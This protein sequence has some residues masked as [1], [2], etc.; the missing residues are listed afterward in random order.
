MPPFLVRLSP[1][2]AHGKPWIRYSLALL[3]SLLAW[4]AASPARAAGESSYPF[5]YAFAAVILSAGWAGAGPGAF[6]TLLC[7]FWA[8]SLQLHD[9]G[10]LN[11]AITRCLVFFAEGLLLSGCSG[12][13][14]R[15]GD[16]AS[17]GQT[18]YR[19]LAETALEGIWQQD[20][21]SEITWAN[22][23][24]AELLG[25]SMD[26]LVGRKVDDFYFPADIAMERIRSENLATG[27]KQQ[28]D[29]RL[30][31]SDGAE[32]W[33]LAC[34]NGL[35]DSQGK[36]TSSLAM[37]TDITERKRAERAL[38]QSEQRYRSL[39]E[40]VLEGVY[41]STPDG[42][43]LAANPMLLKMLDC[44]NEA[45]LQKLN[46]ERDLYAD[47][48]V[49]RRLLERLERDGGFQN[50]EYDIRTAKGNIIRVLENARVIRDENGEIY[51]EGTLSD[52]TERKRV[53]EQLRQ[54]QKV[55]AL[56]RLAGGI[57]QDFNTV[58]RSIAADL[59]SVTESLPLSH[60]ARLRAEQALRSADRATDLT[61]QL[62]SFSRRPADV[63]GDDLKRLVAQHELPFETSARQ[64][65]LLVEDE[66]LV[67]ELSRDV[68][69]QQGY[70]V[71]PVGGP[72]EAEQSGAASA[73]DLLITPLRMPALSG[74]ELAR[75]LRAIHPR[76]KVLFIRG[77]DDPPG[78]EPHPQV[79]DS[80]ILEKPFSADSL[81]RRIRQILHGDGPGR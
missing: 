47:P 49:R 39:F 46:I 62:L 10:T 22:P 12:L 21:N 19:N 74:A 15:M 4:L 55:E 72:G 33:V 1:P 36:V 3:A 59:Q 42:R 28:F 69:E 64:T 57:A 11:G 17:R 23:R 75:R 71:V 29:R 48:S 41:Q 67:R 76:M 56:G 27:L 51:Y 50:V 70:R 73:P 45:E 65:I 80:G 53:E 14:V 31:R 8:G 66:P 58:L 26:R 78:S 37:M 43:I 13:I 40:N 5:I 32:V 77:Y 63:S 79:A 81:G 35:T 34:C 60:P 24:I 68:L 54:A 30:R 6:S 2:L 16:D 25:V 44:A 20:S 18:W 7:T 61:R 9:P 38:R 52:I